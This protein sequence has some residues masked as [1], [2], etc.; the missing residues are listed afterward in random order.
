MS[1]TDYESPAVGWTDLKSP[2]VGLTTLLVEKKSPV[3]GWA[4]LNRCAALGL[5]V[6]IRYDFH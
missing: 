1:W 6:F 3:V 4:D 2:V 5:K